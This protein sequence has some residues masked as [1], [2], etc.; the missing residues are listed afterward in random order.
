MTKKVV[1]WGYP[2]DTHTHSYI[3]LGFAKAFAYL[4]YD[5]VWCDD[6]SDYADEVKDSIVITEKNCINHLPIEK[7]SQYFIHNLA[8]DF[9]KHKGD[10]IH[11]L[12]VY[13]EGYNWGVDWQS[14]DDWSW[15]DKGH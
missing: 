5:V 8:D 14:I 6:D 12:L 9:K 11:N 1:I 3:H 13:H 10:N 15:Y 4:D 7:S 2:P